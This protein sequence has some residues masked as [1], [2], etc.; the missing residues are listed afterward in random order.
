MVENTNFLFNI[1]MDINVIFRK[2]GQVIML[3]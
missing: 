1:K 3:R 2:L